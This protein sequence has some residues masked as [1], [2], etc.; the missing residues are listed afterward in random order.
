[1]GLLVPLTSVE[2]GFE[3]LM[4]AL[5][6]ICGT[7]SVIRAPSS[8]E[9]AK[10]RSEGFPPPTASFPL[11]SAWAFEGQM[12]S[13]TCREAAEPPVILLSVAACLPLTEETR[14]VRR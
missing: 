14:F 2:G 7:D 4:S 9:G 12:T 11:D 1:M 5:P 13:S 6:R 3:A 10:Q 8:A